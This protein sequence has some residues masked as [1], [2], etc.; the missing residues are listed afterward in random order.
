MAHPY[1]DLSRFPKPWLGDFVDEQAKEFRDT[2]RWSREQDLKEAAQRQTAKF[3]DEQNANSARARAETERAARVKEAMKNA[4]SQQ[5]DVKDITALLG[6]GRSGEAMARAASSQYENPDKA[7]PLTRGATLQHFFQGRNG[8][9][10][11]WDKSAAEDTAPPPMM[12]EVRPNEVLAKFLGKR[13]QPETLEPPAFGQPPRPPEPP[14]DPEVEGNQMRDASTEL[15][16]MPGMQMAGAGAAHMQNREIDES[17]KFA[18]GQYEANKDSIAKERTEGERYGLQFPGG[19]ETII[20]PREAKAGLQRDA[21]ERASQLEQ[22]AARESNPQTRADMMRSAAMIRAQAS[23][24]TQAGVRATAQQASGQDF[25]HARDERQVLTREE[26]LD[27]TRIAAS[28]HHTGSQAEFDIAKA[29]KMRGQAA[30]V[31]DPAIQQLLHNYGFDKL[32]QDNQQL[33]NL[34]S[35]GDLAETDP[36]AKTLLSGRFAKFAQGAGVLSDSDM[37]TFYTD[38]GGKLG[39]FDSNGNVDLTKVRNEIRGYLTGTSDAR[40]TAN[41]EHALGRLGNVIDNRTNEM[42]GKIETLMR[43]RGASDDAIKSVVGTYAPRYTMHG[44]GTPGDIGD[45]TIRKAPPRQGRG[46]PVQ[47]GGAPQGPAAGGRPPPELLKHAQ[48][49]LAANPNDATAKAFV[50]KWGGSP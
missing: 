19:P 20:D 40:F 11:D 29:E 43:G 16:G 25:T 48:E 1:F 33:A 21:E 3:E 24:A 27:K 42:G 13:A 15:L 12:G 5:G 7:G 23:N 36:A 26:Q 9:R 39:L 44:A 2:R 18:Q 10:Q 47:P 41:I 32:Q 30:A 38:I 22:A 31:Y 37:K 4:A 17:N 34:F 28:G 45:R 14:L 50:A 49:R 8:Q 46:G 6:A 35:L